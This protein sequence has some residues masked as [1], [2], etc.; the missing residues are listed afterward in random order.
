M[1]SIYSTLL[2]VLQLYS[3]DYRQIKEE[4]SEI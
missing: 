4:M 3:T 1:I 2:I